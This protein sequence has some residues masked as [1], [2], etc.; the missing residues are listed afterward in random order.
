M[1]QAV[2]HGAAG[3]HGPSGT[4]VRF[5][6]R[7]RRRLLTGARSNVTIGASVLKSAQFQRQPWRAERDFYH[8]HAEAA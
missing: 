4:R 3:T 6:R 5:V 1:A 8:N 7:G 2:T